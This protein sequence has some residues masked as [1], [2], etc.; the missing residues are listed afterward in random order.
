MHAA[1]VEGA[2]GADRGDAAVADAAIGADVAKEANDD[3]A[4]PLSLTLLAGLINAGPSSSGGTRL[5][6]GTCLSGI[7]RVCRGG[8]QSATLV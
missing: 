2:T 1:M 3:C 7:S 6:T 4:A 5:A 8:M